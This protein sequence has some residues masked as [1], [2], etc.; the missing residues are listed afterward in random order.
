MNFQRAKAS[1]VITPAAV[2]QKVDAALLRV[3]VVS[4]WI[5]DFADEGIKKFA[6][7]LVQAF[8]SYSDVLGISLGAPS[9]APNVVNHR[10]NKLLLSPSLRRQVRSF[11]PDIIFYVPTASDTVFSFL[12]LKIL[13]SYCPQATTILVALQPRTRG[14]LGQ[15]LVRRAAPDLVFVPSRSRA[16]RIQSEGLRADWIPS[17]VDVERFTPVSAESKRTLRA[18]YGL[19]QDTFLA[20][21]VGHISKERNIPSLVEIQRS[22]QVVF[23]TGNSV[24]EDDEMRR[25]LD[26]A[27]V[28]V[29]DQYL[30]AIEEIYQAADCYV[31][32]VSSETGS[33]ETPLSL[34]EAMACNL[35]LVSTRFGGLEDLFDSLDSCAEAGLTLIDDLQGLGGAIAHVRANPVARTRE[36]VQRYSWDSIASRLLNE[37][38]DIKELRKQVNNDK[39]N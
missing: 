26:D 39:H 14:R 17:G 11:A 13:A 37:S 27:G 32:P 33:I 19:P 6:S 24:G 28:I 29:L 5:S 12:R 31:F 7:T 10:T 22:Y 2:S 1:S 8:G 34:L 23:V 20:L 25:L 21:H 9:E 16:A 35:P 15:W 3:C 36:L 30:E 4:E 38:Y 18:K